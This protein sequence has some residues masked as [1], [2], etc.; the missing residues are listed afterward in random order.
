MYDAILDKKK[1]YEEMLQLREEYGIEETE[2]LQI[3]A[4]DVSSQSMTEQE[5]KLNED[6]KAV[7]DTVIAAVAREDIAR[8]N[9]SRAGYKPLTMFV[10]GVGKGSLSY[11]TFQ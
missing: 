2:A 7:Y 5:T 3:H 8:K 9:G 1:D 11:I 6:Q 4:R 10:S